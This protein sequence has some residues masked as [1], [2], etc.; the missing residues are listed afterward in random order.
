MGTK[1]I[2]HFIK[3]ETN[4]YKRKGDKGLFYP[5]GFPG[6]AYI[7]DGRQKKQID[8]FNYVFLFFMAIIAVGDVV[9][10]EVRFISLDTGTFIFHSVF[11]VI[12]LTGFIIGCLYVQKLTPY[13]EQESNRAEKKMISW[14]I[15]LFLYTVPYFLIASIAPA[16]LS[17]KTFIAV[18]IS[19]ICAFYLLYKI[20]IAKGYIFNK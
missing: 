20:Q 7:I 19:G 8:G 15:L 12:G 10:E 3:K 17:T 6:E 1:D 11:T 18:L 14:W 2:T 5:W 16:F 13:L 9:L 4:Y